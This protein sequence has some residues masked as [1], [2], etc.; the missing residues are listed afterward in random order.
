M[1]MCSVSGV[2]GIIG[3]DLTPEIVA[4]YA[5]AYGTVLKGG[6][7]VIAWDTRPTGGMIRAAA[8]SGLLS[9]GCDV[10]AIGVAPTPTVP[11]AVS[12]FKAAG[13][14]AITASHNPIEWNALKFIGSARSVMP[15]RTISK[16]YETVNQDRIAY[17][18]WDRIG[19]H[20]HSDAMVDHHVAAVLR[21][22]Q[23]D[24]DAIQKHRPVIV[25]DA[26]GGAGARYAPTLLKRL[27][28]R[29]IELYCEAGPRFPRGPEPVPKNLGALGKAVRRH[30]ADFGFATDPDSDRLAIVD[31]RGRPLGEERTLILATY[32]VLTQTP[33][34][35]VINLSTSRGVLDVAAAFGQRGYTSKVGEV[36]VAE[37]MK[38]KR[39][40]IGGEGNGGVI[41]PALHPGRDALLGMALTASLFAKTG[42]PVSEIAAALPTYYAAKK[43]IP[44]PTDFP[45][46]L[47][48]LADHYKHDRLDRRD[49][50]KVEFDDGSVQARTSNTEPIMRIS[51][52]AKTPKRAKEM[53]AAALKAL[54]L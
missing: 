2:R 51:A 12:H 13:G 26:G 6:R 52:E 53:L 48:R 35:V 38:A 54:G 33:G 47:D 31:E 43:A 9:A 46:R 22:P 8:L 17:K 41:M 5:A 27:G 44:R 36:N 32:W 24:R 3:A 34:P 25:Y 16:V 42:A 37:M 15:A 39:A 40:I 50:V 11:L 1:L 29:V 10:I 18:A 45:K 20:S 19:L 49:G 14:L 23:V 21:L 28:C 4:R 30:R 7:V